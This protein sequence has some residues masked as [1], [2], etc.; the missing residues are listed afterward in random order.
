MTGVALEL[1]AT[2]RRRRLAQTLELMLG[3]LMFTVGERVAP[4]AGMDLNDRRANRARRFDLRRFGSDEERHADAGSRQLADR[5]PQGVA[6]A[7]GVETAFGGALGAAFRD[8]A[9]GMGPKLTGNADHFRCRCHFQI[10][11]LCDAL[12]EANDIVIDNMAAILAKMRSDAVGAGRDRDLGCLD[13]VRI[14]P[15]TRIAHGGDV[16]DVDPEPDDKIN[17]VPGL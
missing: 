16:I 17:A 14:M 8:N 2:R 3:A 5:R 1:Q 9:G 13:R 11:R 4:G 7:R 15:A 10:E 6:L 12:L